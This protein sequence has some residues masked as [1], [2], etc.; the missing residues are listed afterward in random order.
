MTLCQT[1]LNR[2]VRILTEHGGHFVIW[3]C[4]VHRIRFGT[5]EEYK[6]GNKQKIDCKEYESS[7]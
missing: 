6:A 3:G 2:R 4:P 5:D 1:C 7:L